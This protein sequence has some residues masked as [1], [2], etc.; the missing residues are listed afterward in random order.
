MKKI[1]YDQQDKLEAFFKEQETWFPN[2]V[3]NKFLGIFFIGM[4]LILI[5]F[6]YYSFE[7]DKSFIKCLVMM[8]AMYNY[9]IY[10]LVAKY[11]TY[12]E[13]GKNRRSIMELVKYLPVEKIQ[14]TYFKGRKIFKPCIF[15]TAAIVCLHII[16]SFG[17]YGTV[18]V[19]DILLPVVFCFLFPMSN[20][21]W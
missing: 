3:L 15:L 10:F 6:P 12:V 11:T 17:C 7:G 16:I 1:D 2:Y 21:L 4:S 9:G 8:Y 5:L 14:L 19:W 18:S 13:Q 20:I